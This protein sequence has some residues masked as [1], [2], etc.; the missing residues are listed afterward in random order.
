MTDLTAT[1]AEERALRTG[2][3]VAGAL[4]L[5]LAA[6]LIFAP[7]TFFDEFADYGV[8]NDHYMRDV[9][10]AYVGLGVAM[11]LAASRPSWRA[12]ILWMAV[13]WTAAHALN[14]LWDV[15]AAHTGWVGP[16]NLALIALSAV[17]YAWLAVIAG[18][19][20]R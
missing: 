3:L 19:A 5:A 6:V 17:L 20:E 16:V 2:L 12:P 7:G 11:L 15:D 1:P 10:T 4:N 8:Q 18:R 14:H 9:G 13:I